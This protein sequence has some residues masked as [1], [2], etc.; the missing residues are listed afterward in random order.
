MCQNMVFSLKPNHDTPQ[1]ISIHNSEESSKGDY[2]TRTTSCC[3]ATTTTRVH[4][5]CDHQRC[6]NHYKN[7]PKRLQESSYVFVLFVIKHTKSEFYVFIFNGDKS[8]LCAS[9][10][11][12]YYRVQNCKLVIYQLC[13]K[14][15][16]TVKP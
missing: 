13:H 9:E 14:D 4:H 7:Y 12:K 8:M 6:H 3:T 15:N 10:S 5:H 11:G 2:T 1:N 16:V